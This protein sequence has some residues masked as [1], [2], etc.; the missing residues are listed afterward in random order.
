MNAATGNGTLTTTA[1]SGSF[2]QNTNRYIVT[3]NW[4]EDKVWNMEIPVSGFTGGTLKISFIPQS[5][6]TGPKDFAV[7]WS[8]DNINWSTASD[9]QKY[10]VEN[11]SGKDKEISITPS[12]ITDKLYI[13]LRVTS[14]TSANNTGTVATAGTSRLTTKLTIEQE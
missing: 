11:A 13:R 2:T 7:E 10:I 6:N 12:G 8:A 9:E 3:T 1:N 14:N 5:S 4:T